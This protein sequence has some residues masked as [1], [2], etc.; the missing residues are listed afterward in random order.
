[1]RATSYNA[2]LLQVLGLLNL[3]TSTVQPA[4]KTKINSFILRRSRE[5]VQFYWWPETMRVEERYMRP[6][7]DNGATYAAP[8]GTVANEVYFPGS[9]SYYQNLQ[10]TTG[11]APATLTGNVWVTNLTYWAPVQ[12]T[13]AAPDWL[14]NTA[15]LQ[16]KQVRDPA[17]GFYKQCTVAHTSASSLDGTKFGILTRFLPYIG[18]DQAN[19]AGMPGHTAVGLVR[20]VFLDN[21]L[22][23]Q[24]PR[25]L[26]H[27]LGPNGIA[28]PEMGYTSAFLWFQIKP[29]V[30]TGAV[31][32][33]VTAAGITVYY[34]SATAGFDGDYWTASVTTN[35]GES[36]ESQPTKFTKQEIPEG[37]RDAIAHAAYSDMLR[38]I[39]KDDEVS[40]EST[41]GGAFLADEVRKYMAMQRQPGTWSFA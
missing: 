8:S 34:S 16:G 7:Y 21:P 12:C 2:I 35:S 41:A 30:L 20:G 33:G 10:A 1:M 15:Y 17:D 37:L 39:A 9:K 27:V 18:L 19:D 5:A 28:L 4:D 26:G 14:A 23:R 3:D 13:Y 22:V 36:P 40:I 25:R 32:A 31:C 38:P 29:P 24:R 11:N 6:F